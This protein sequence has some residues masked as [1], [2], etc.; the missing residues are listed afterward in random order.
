[1]RFSQDFFLFFDLILSCEITLLFDHLFSELDVPE[2][3]LLEI[4]LKYFLHVQSPF[5]SAGTSS[6]GLS[7]FIISCVLCL[8][9]CDSSGLFFF[10]VSGFVSA[11]WTTLINFN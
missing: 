6:P 7:E 11:G 10:S 4:A 5:L 1:M 2:A 9:H 3:I 8:T